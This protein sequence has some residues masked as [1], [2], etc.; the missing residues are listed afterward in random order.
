M[1]AYA[2]APQQRTQQSHVHSLSHWSTSSSNRARSSQN[3]MWLDPSIVTQRA[4]GTSKKRGA[5]ACVS[6]V[7]AAP[8]ITKTG[9]VTRWSRPIAD[10]SCNL[11]SNLASWRQHTER[12]R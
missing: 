10:Q 9:T 12:G 2:K 6:A 3:G 4:R 11:W 5:T 7:S 1:A 8:L